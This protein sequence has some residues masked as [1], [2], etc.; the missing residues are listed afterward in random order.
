MI[1]T[2]T[3]RETEDIIA[4]FVVYLQSL[5]FNVIEWSA[6]ALADFYDT[7]APP[8]LDLFDDADAAADH[9]MIAHIM[10]HTFLTF[11]V[12]IRADLVPPTAAIDDIAQSPLSAQERQRLSETIARLRAAPQPTQ[13]TPEWYLF[14]Y[15]LITA[16]NAYKALGSQALKN[17][18]IYEKCKPLVTT[19]DALAT[20]ETATLA[21]SPTN[22]FAAFKRMVNT[23][24]PTH[25]GQRY[26]PLS[27]AIYEKLNN[28]HIADF[29]C[30]AHP[31][32]PFLGASP[33]GINDA[34]N[35]PLYGRMLEIKNVVSREITGVPKHEYAIQMQMQME[36]CD[37]DLCDF[38]E[39]KFVEFA[40]TDDFFE[41][42]YQDSMVETVQG[43]EIPAFHGVILQFQHATSENPT[44]IYHIWDPA[45]ETNPEHDID[46]W[47]KNTI[48]A[49]FAAA[50]VDMYGHKNIRF[51]QKHYWRLEVYSC[52]LVERDRTWFQNNVE[53]FRALWD[54]VL[55]ERVS[56]Y[57]HRAPVRRAGS[58]AAAAAA[59]A[60]ATT[61]ITDFFPFET[62]DGGDTPATDVKTITYTPS[63]KYDSDKYSTCMF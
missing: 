12:E 18:L 52:I 13:R 26:E 21:P 22:P 9:H 45:I 42:L 33:D 59:A 38:L 51:I 63:A 43:D 58:K 46:L 24:L 32:Y 50:D 27:V 10:Y 7:I 62:A 35:S 53:Q 30:I 5:D 55:R 16:S 49:Q 1:I 19:A 61:T 60:A 14:R 41:S 8:F 28:T 39:T 15:D 40:T 44:Y 20:T 4:S 56:G 48:R 47:E 25:W 11:I 17:S 37:L 36:V 29:G 54:T 6:P 2:L 23:T 3:D 31:Q 34:P 57:E